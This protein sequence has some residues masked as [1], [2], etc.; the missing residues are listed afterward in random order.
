MPD[1]VDASIPL[2]AARLNPQPGP[3]WPAVLTMQR[4]AQAGQEQ[5]GLNALRQVYQNPANIGPNGLPTPTAVGQVGRVAPGEAM[6]LSRALTADRIGEAQA[7]MMR[8]K[9]GDEIFRQKLFIGQESLDAY[10]SAKKDGLPEAAARQAGQDAWNA[11]RKNL[12]SFAGPDAMGTLPTDFDPQRVARGVAAGN[13]AMLTPMQKAQLAERQQTI[14][15]GEERLTI[16]Q[17]KA[18][19]AQQNADRAAKN[20]EKGQWQVLTDPGKTDASGKPLQYRYNPTTAKAT[21]LSGEPYDPSGAAK[22]GAG[23]TGASASPV[24]VEYWAN[25][26]R[27]GGSLPPGLARTK[28]GSDMVRQIM[29]KV[30]N[31]GT[32]PGQFIA[33]H[34]AT[35]ANTTSLG[36]MTKMTDAATSFERTAN[37][38]FDLALSLSKGAVPTNWGPWL[39]RW[40]ESGQTAFGNEQVPAYVTAML[41]AANEYAKIMSGSTGS[42]GSTVDSRREAAQL[43]SPYLSAGQI[44]R[45]VGIAKAD[46]ANRKASLYGQLDE[47]KERLGAEAPGKTG[48]PAPAA[49]SNAAA[50][51]PSGDVHSGI[52]KEQYDALSPGSRYTVPGDPRVFVKQ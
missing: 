4:I 2:D 19:I 41:T 50:L 21:T 32:D 35:K 16:E 44:D 40:V 37:K 49:S 11:G 29:A 9:E 12:A 48:A 10:Q 3:N 30:P 18:A 43:F 22:I 26:L 15:Q 25:V 14:A 38:N 24:E 13:N 23:D 28:Q 27:N 36:N 47:I 1:Y 33:N 39:N 5:A 8:L 42:Q 34:A 7:N 45:V 46:M 52:S 51:P 20:A 31:S 17:Q 6:D